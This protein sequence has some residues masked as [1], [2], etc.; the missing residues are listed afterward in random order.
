MLKFRI[1]TE[2][3]I[4]QKY[5]KYWLNWDKSIVANTWEWTER[6]HTLSGT[7]VCQTSGSDSGQP[8]ASVKPNPLSSGIYSPTV[9]IH[10]PP[11]Q[12]LPFFPYIQVSM[13]VT[14]QNLVTFNRKQRVSGLRV[15]V[16]NKQS[17]KS[18]YFKYC[19]CVT[20]LWCYDR[21]VFFKWIVKEL[22]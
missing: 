7:N 2:I 12:S 10:P 8:R 18:E 9:T 11:F 13:P 4:Y 5:Q 17:Q 21:N 15:D 19:Y 22:P 3:S 1:C 16:S 6:K 20:Y 14:F